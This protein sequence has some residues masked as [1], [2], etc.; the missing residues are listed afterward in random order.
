[1]AKGRGARGLGVS[2]ANLALEHGAFGGSGVGASRMI[3]PQVIDNMIA[4]ARDKSQGTIRTLIPVR[5]AQPGA[6]PAQAG[7]GQ[8]YP[9]GARATSGGKPIVMTANGWQLVSQ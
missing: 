2:N 8:Q 1:M 3:T 4:D 6:A 9:I 5:G 7:G